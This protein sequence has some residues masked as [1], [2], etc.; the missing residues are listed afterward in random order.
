MLRNG[1]LLASYKDGSARFNAY[2]DDY[3]FLLDALLELLQA[4]W[5]TPVLQ[6]AERLADT[7]LDHFLDADSGGFF[8]TADD[9]ETLMHRPKPLADES[10]ASG[11][12]VAVLALQRLGFLL[13]E[14][15]Y[16]QAA[17]KTLR[18]AAGMMSQHPHAHVTLLTALEEYLHNPEIVI[19]RGDPQVIAKWRDA[20]ARIYAPRR[21]VFAI[22]RDCGDLP[23]ALAERRAGTG[24]ALAYRCVGSHCSLPI[25]SLDALEGE[26]GESGAPAPDQ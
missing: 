5:H 3:A 8:F 2:L 26:L 13:G 15:R 23:G 18:Y 10:M 6:T 16:L 11:N 9:H 17:E 7:L 21:L 19:I 12:G 4:D 20:C 24:E 1:R 25:A 14:R 22:P